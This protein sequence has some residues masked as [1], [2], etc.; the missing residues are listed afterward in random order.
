[1]KNSVNMC[2]TEKKIQRKYALHHSRNIW[3]Y[4]IQIIVLEIT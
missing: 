3:K 4:N 1:M 2:G